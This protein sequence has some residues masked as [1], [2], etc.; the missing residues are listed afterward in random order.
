MSS[1]SVPR[2]GLRRGRKDWS[3]VG[4][5]LWLRQERREIQ[6]ISQWTTEGPPLCKSSSRRPGPARLDGGADAASGTE[7]AAHHGPHRIAGLDHVLQNLVH[8]VLL[9]DAQIAVARSRP[10]AS[11][12]TF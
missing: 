12:I 9:E 4:K 3:E 5:R 10:S 11:C 1:S 2:A 6:R 7:L 8:D